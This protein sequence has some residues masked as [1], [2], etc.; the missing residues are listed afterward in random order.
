MK[1]KG[2]KR[3]PDFIKKDMQHPTT[4]PPKKEMGE[5]VG[6]DSKSNDS[7]SK[8]GVYKIFH[9]FMKKFIKEQEKAKKKGK[10]IKILS[11]SSNKTFISLS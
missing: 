11:S 9:K 6:K 5:L 4:T 10:K 1:E 3:K 2:R 8:W 7:E